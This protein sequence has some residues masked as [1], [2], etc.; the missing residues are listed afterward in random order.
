[1]A[2]LYELIA[3]RE[4]QRAMENTI[5]NKNIEKDKIDTTK[6]VALMNSMSHTYGNALAF[7]QN[8]IINLFPKDLFKTIHVNSKIAHRQIRST[9]HEYIKKIKPMIIFRP[10]IPTYDEDRFL[11]DTP[12]IERMTDIYSSWGNTALMD[13]FHDDDTNLSIKY[14]L[15]RVVMYV[16]VSLYFQ[17][18]IQQLNYYHYIENAVRINHP[19]RLETCFE[20]FL[21]QQMLQVISDY[22]KIPIYDEFGNTK[23]FVNY[24]NGHSGFP[25]TYKLQGS[26]NSREFYRYYPVSIDTIITDLDKDDG[27]RVGNT[28]DQYQIS[29][30]VRMEFF[31]N[32]FYFIY[33]ENI[34][35]L[36]LPIVDTSDSSIIPIFTDIHMREDLD[37]PIGWILYNQGSCR[38][39]S[40]DDTVNFKQMLNT[41]I[42]DTLAYHEK[43]GLPTFDFIDIKIRKQGEIIHEGVDY[44]IDWKNLDIHFMDCNTFYTYHINV[45]LN[46]EYINDL[47]KTIYHLK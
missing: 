12:M 36:N 3:E 21:P 11:K 25:I 1:M 35:D 14:Q 17:T 13:F 31:T 38:L 27:D 29:F 43:N 16:D 39:E 22:V 28:F 26:T 2:Y 24:M 10:R 4:K 9:T 41:S 20:S 32:G 34:H 33:G 45:C 6:Y 7:M 30:T 44:I 40:G 18:L 23:E 15:N 5:F 47:M 46:V 19:F 42:V 37:M 8:W